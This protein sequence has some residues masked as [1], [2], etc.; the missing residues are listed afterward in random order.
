M[1]RTTI[2]QPFI[3][4]LTKI[5][6]YL[7]SSLYGIDICSIHCPKIPLPPYDITNSSPWSL[8]LI[9]HAIRYMTTGLKLFHNGS[10]I[11]LIV[12]LIIPSCNLWRR[13]PPADSRPLIHIRE[14]EVNHLPYQHRI[15]IMASSMIPQSLSFSFKFY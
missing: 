3:S 2:F 5:S 7:N 8:L 14:E 13:V 15:D 11:T 4:L 6:S 9:H 10:L 1:V 12:I